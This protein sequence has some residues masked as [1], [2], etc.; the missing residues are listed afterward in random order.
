MKCRRRKKVMLP[1][2]FFA[3]Q[4]I[5][6]HREFS[7]YKDWYCNVNFNG[8][9]E[10]VKELL[11]GDI[12]NPNIINDTDVKEFVNTNYYERFIKY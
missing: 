6:C 2:S 12:L 8:N 3:F 7:E 5:K 10:Y 4:D 9:N 1:V 11:N